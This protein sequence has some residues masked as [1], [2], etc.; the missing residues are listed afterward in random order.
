M[1]GKSASGITRPVPLQL[2][3]IVNTVAELE[4]D[5]KLYVEML[6]SESDNEAR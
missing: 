3:E 5:V 4:G 6:I 1:K 2:L